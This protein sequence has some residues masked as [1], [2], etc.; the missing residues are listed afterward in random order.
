MTS[1]ERITAYARCLFAGCAR[2]LVVGVAALFVTYM[3]GP[4]QGQWV[5]CPVSGVALCTSSTA[6]V[7]LGYSGLSSA[8]PAMLSLYA[9]SLSIIG[10][11]SQ[12]QSGGPGSP[13]YQFVGTPNG[14]RTGMYSPTDPGG[15]AY[16]LG[17]SV[18]GAEQLRID[19]MVRV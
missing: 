3:A 18:I 7:G 6:T 10:G 13:S 4:L 16:G 8:P 19:S 5:N 11:I 15:N 17:F 14:Y 1:V 12:V 2:I 9:G